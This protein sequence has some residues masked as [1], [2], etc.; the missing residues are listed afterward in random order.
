MASLDEDNRLAYP[1][2]TMGLSE[3]VR[4]VDDLSDGG[5]FKFRFHCDKC[6]DGVES[7]YAPAATNLLKTGLEIF[8]MFRPLGG[9]RRAVDGIDRGLRGKER[10]RA[11]QNAVKLAKSHFSK[12]TSCGKWVCAH[13]YNDEFALC[14]TCAPNADERAARVAAARKASARERAVSSGAVEPGPVLCAACHAPSG[15]GKF[16]EACGAP[17]SPL[18]T[19]KQCGEK[20]RA[21][22]QFCG[23]CGQKAE[24]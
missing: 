17:H 1:K 3:F 4:N 23:A 18:H 11:Y 2:S 15:G 10:D 22:A 8:Q 7:H 12:C 24:T 9:A 6:R 20:M 19:C 5:G 21:A 14:E 13:C 16:C